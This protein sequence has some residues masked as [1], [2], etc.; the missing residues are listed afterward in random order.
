MSAS[1]IG[2]FR[3]KSILKFTTPSGGNMDLELKA[4]TPVDTGVVELMM[5]IPADNTQAWD[6]I[7]ERIAKITD[8]K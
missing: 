2:T 7:R 1:R 6:R 4:G 8:K 3:T 5:L